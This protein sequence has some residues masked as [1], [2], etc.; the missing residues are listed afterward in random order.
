MA[1]FKTNLS[2]GVWRF[3]LDSPD[4]GQIA[5]QRKKICP[6]PKYQKTKL[7]EVTKRFRL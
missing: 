5:A 2:A 4:E 7:Y 1:V 3:A 6:K